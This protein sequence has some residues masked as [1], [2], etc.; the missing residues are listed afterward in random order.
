MRRSN[1]LYSKETVSN[2]A[3]VTF[4][5]FDT[6]SYE[7]HRSDD[8]EIERDLVYIHGKRIVDGMDGELITKWTTMNLVRCIVRSFLRGC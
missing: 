4:L 6:Q 5:F 1:C 2:L 8:A 7:K 3:G